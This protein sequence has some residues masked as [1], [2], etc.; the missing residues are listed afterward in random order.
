M[1]QNR[2]LKTSVAAAMFVLLGI[3]VNTGCKKKDAPFDVTTGGKGGNAVLLV[4]PEH[5]GG[6]VDS[7]KI[8]IKYATNDAPA[9]VSLYDDSAWCVLQDTTPVATFTNL[10]VGGYYVFGDGYHLPYV[11]ATVRGGLPFNFKTE[12]TV[13]LF[14]PT[15]EYIK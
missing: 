8:Y 7:C 9:N 5:A 12:D 3:A 11:P 10:K 15:S 6:F 2:F 1:N 4:T 14:L 13:H